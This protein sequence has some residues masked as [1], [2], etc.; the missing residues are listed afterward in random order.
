LTYPAE[1]ER[2]AQLAAERA[3]RILLLAPGCP[4]PLLL[5]E[6]EDWVRSPID[7]EELD[8]RLAMLARRA[9]STTIHESICLHDGILRVGD[10]WT[11]IPDGQRRI[12]ALLIDRIDTV[13][14]DHEIAQ[15]HGSSEVISNPRTVKSMMWRLSRRLT[16]VG[17]ALHKVRGRGYLVELIRYGG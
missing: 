6:L 16:D 14:S 13:V 3:P 17:I 7:A 10:R 9:G 15:A 2:R 1:E 11:P 8:A 5:D 4:P 12:V